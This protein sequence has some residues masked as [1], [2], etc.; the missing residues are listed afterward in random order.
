MLLNILHTTRTTHTNF[1]AAAR[2]DCHGALEAAE[3]QG[4]EIHPDPRYPNS[5]R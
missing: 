2:Q 5:A 4:L 3:S 1:C